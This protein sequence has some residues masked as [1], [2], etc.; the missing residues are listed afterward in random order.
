MPE[1]NVNPNYTETSIV[2]QRRNGLLLSFECFPAKTSQG[3]E[4]LHETVQRL[5]AWQPDFISVTCGADGSSTE[6]TFSTVKN[7]R[8]IYGLSIAPHIA[9]SRS[10]RPTLHRLLQDYKKIGIEYVVA[11]RGDAAKIPT[12]AEGQDFYPTTVEFVADLAGYFKLKPLVG[13]YPDVHPLALSPEQ[14]IEHLKRKIDVGASRAITQFFFD[15]ETYLRFRDR[16]R[17]AGVD[18]PIIPGIMPLHNIK[19]IIS[20]SQTCGARVPDDFAVRFID[21]ATDP[22]GYFD[23]AVAYVVRLCQRLRQEGIDGF[24]FY[25][26]NRSEMIDALCTELSFNQTVKTQQSNV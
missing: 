24:H 3:A 11:I 13:A 19:Q 23:Q 16:A 6:G 8:D 18:I 12:L 25:A 21:E 9:M 15:A 10:D 2:A 7:L 22:K 5:S 20:F 1:S 17:A 4:R 14:D 26:L